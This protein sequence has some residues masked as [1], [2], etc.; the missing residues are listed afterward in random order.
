M[1][2]AFNNF[3]KTKPAPVSNDSVT[4]LSQRPHETRRLSHGPVD[5]V[6]AAWHRIDAIDANLKFRKLQKQTLSQ[7]RFRS[8][9]T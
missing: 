3:S 2:S 1:I 4:K 5:G 9:R 8:G 7:H 6:V